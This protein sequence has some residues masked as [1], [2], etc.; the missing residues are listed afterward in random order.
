[1]SNYLA[2][3]FTQLNLLESEQFSFDKEGAAKL[4]N[5]MEDD[6]LSDLEVVIDPEA[7]TEDDLRDSYIGMGI[8]GCEIC[9]S[10]IYKDMEDIKV[11]EEAH[12]ANVGECC[13]YCYSTDGFK[14]VGKVAP[15]EDITVET[16]KEDVE[17]KVN[18][19]DVEVDVEGIEDEEVE[20]PTEQLEEALD[21]DTVKYQEYVDHDIQEYGKVAESTITELERAGLTLTSDNKVISKQDREDEEVD[22]RQKYPVES[23]FAKKDSTFVKKSGKYPVEKEVNESTSNKI[24]GKKRSELKEATGVPTCLRYHLLQTL[25]PCSSV[26]SKETTTISGVRMVSPGRMEILK[27]SALSCCAAQYRMPPS[28]FLK[29]D[30]HF[31]GQPMAMLCP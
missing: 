20:E 8:L 4:A 21:T 27:S 5:F 23:P 6:A 12:L 24:M 28:T 18:G 9:K 19:K 7:E 25:M 3:A 13:P 10:M 26:P 11:D 16:D 31:P 2:E 14:V 15:F 22:P 1:M 17:V 29:S 30:S